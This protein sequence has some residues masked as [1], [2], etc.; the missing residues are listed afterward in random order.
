MRGQMMRKICRYAAYTLAGLLLV[1]LLMVGGGAVWLWG[2]TWKGAP[3]FH[4]SWTAAERSAITEF[5]TYLRKQYAADAEELLLTYAR[6]LPDIWGGEPR[7]SG[8]VE[9]LAAAYTARMIA[10][11]VSGM[12]HRIAQSGDSSS[13][14]TISFQG[15]H[16]LTP[17]IVA[18]QTGHLEALEALVLHGANPNAIAIYKPDDYTEPM[19]VDT[20]ISPLLNG[21]FT[22]GR[23]L[24]WALRRQTAEFLLANGG[25]L[26]ASHSINKLSCDMALMLHTAEGIAPWEWALNNGMN[27]NSNNLSLI[28]LFA[29]GRPV[30]ERVLREKSVDIN[31]VTGSGTVLQY[32]I[33][34]LLRPYDEE[35]WRKEQPEKVLEEHLPLLLAAGANPNLIP[36]EA[37]PQRPGESDEEYE[38]RI[39]NSDALRD[40]P[41]GI[42]TKA[43]ERAKL[44]AH[45]ELCLR[46]I[47]KLKLA[48]AKTCPPSPES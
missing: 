16:G 38:A 30:L 11:P 42:A 4:E 47:E 36:S 23:K 15:V 28:V 12:L 27:I 6:T 32:L 7:S 1:L 26:N 34:V 2:W 13:A 22:N 25:N 18:A 9:H 19:E 44:P 10:A 3:T 48:G 43:L 17:A 21:H 29:E 35:M 14:D 46:I 31:D 33:R 8:V 41:L 37:E 39:D 45:R 5:D 24:P 20:P 40:T